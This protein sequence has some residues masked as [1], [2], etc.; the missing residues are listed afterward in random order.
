[1]RQLVA[2][3]V[4]LGFIAGVAFI[5]HVNETT[6]EKTHLARKILF[7]T[8][9]L[10]ALNPEQEDKLIFYLTK[11]LGTY[12]GSFEI[13]DVVNLQSH[14]IGA[15]AYLLVTLRA[16]NG[17]FCQV[18]ISR[19]NLPWARWEIEQGSFKVVDIKQA[20]YVTTNENDLIW[21]K[22][23][24]ITPEEVHR[25]LAAHPEKA[26]GDA[27]ALFLDQDTG[28]HAIPKD[29]WK[30]KTPQASFK[31]EINKDKTMRFVS[32]M[33]RESSADLYWKVDYPSDYLGGGYRGYLFDKV[34]GE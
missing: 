6:R 22:E 20:V 11:Q 16:P 33:K 3:L 7:M 17:K 12:E 1:M 30:V 24:G 14:D 32:E 10:N 13:I 9:N 18:I 4:V 5:L 21:M 31:L 19:K 28:Y 2:L 29:F 26:L 27:E 25:Y 34:K 8:D 15:T 23:L